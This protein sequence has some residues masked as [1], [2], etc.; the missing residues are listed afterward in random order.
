VEDQGCGAEWV[1]SQAGRNLLI[2][3]DRTWQKLDAL[4]T[5]KAAGDVPQNVNFALKAS[6]LRTFLDSHS[7]PYTI[8][9]RSV[10]SSIFGSPGLGP[11]EVGDL[12]IV[13]RRARC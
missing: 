5:M 2:C 3:V 9:D 11:A 1:S 13:P 10:S 4:E 8:S 7:I 12:S 6:I